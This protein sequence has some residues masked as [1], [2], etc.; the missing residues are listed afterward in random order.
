[1]KKTELFS[2]VGIGLVLAGLFFF[3]FF[4]IKSNSVLR[5]KS[6]RL[7]NDLK[8]AKVASHQ[9]E[10]LEKT[11]EDTNRK[12]EAIYRRVPENEELP[13]SL[14]KSLLPVA[15]EV[16]LREVKYDLTQKKEQTKEESAGKAQGPQSPE[17][18]QLQQLGIRKTRLTITCKATFPQIIRFVEQ[19]ARLE[20][21]AAVKGI[22]VERD[23]KL[24]PYQKISLQLEAFSFQDKSDDLSSR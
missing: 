19:L 10:D 16:G 12:A 1:M 15:V 3:L 21:V 18:A 11:I 14:V 23:E 9:L 22:V 6:A 24:L 4:Q 5:R 2:T 7:K 13:L 8:N 17:D 20:R